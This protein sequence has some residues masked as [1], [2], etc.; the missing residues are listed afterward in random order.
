MCNQC[1]GKWGHN[2]CN[3]HNNKHIIIKIYYEGLKNNDHIPTNECF[4]LVALEK[5]MN[6]LTY[7]FYYL[8]KILQLVA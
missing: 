6:C 7:K 1:V 8:K 5:I 3:L 4:K 2:E